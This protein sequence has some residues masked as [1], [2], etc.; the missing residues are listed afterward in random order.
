MGSPES[1]A[2]GAMCSARACGPAAPSY[3]TPCHP[4]LRPRRPGPGFHAPGG[5]ARPA[6]EKG[7]DARRRRG[8]DRGVLLYAA[9]RDGGGNE[10]DGPLSAAG[11]ALDGA[12]EAGDVVLDEERIDDRDGDRAEQ[13]PRHELAPEVDVATDELGDHADGNRFLLR[14]G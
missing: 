14:R 10:A 5:D 8:P 7:P 13:R 3:T 11:L 2:P 1:G 9:G 6:A 12:G 4:C